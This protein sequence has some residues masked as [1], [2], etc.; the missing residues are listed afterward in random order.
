MPLSLYAEELGATVPEMRT[1]HYRKRDDKALHA[2]ASTAGQLELG[3]S[4]S[5]GALAPL[6]PPSVQ[7]AGGRRRR[8]AAWRTEQF[9]AKAHVA[10][11]QIAHLLQHPQQ[12][13]SRARAGESI[14]LSASAVAAKRGLVRAGSVGHA[15]VEGSPASCGRER[16]VA[17]RSTRDTWDVVDLIQA[18][19]AAAATPMECASATDTAFARAQAALGHHAQQG[20]GTER[21]LRAV[22]RLCQ[23]DAQKSAATAVNSCCA[24]LHVC[25][26]MREEHG[27]EHYAGTQPVAEAGAQVAAA[28]VVE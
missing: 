20:G 6:E 10:A 2:T 9:R 5:A 11:Q 28:R 3:A 24:A 19:L 16:A 15:R 26:T 23:R 4:I 12:A 14:L 25:S 27:L 22:M 18:D 21:V 1:G 17:I 13:V 8:L 7:R